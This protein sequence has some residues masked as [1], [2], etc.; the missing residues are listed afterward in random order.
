M[1]FGVAMGLALMGVLSA[2]REKARRANC[3][4]N[5]HC[6]TLSFYMYSDIFSGK[7]PLDNHMTIVGSFQL[8]S[9]VSSTAKLLFCPSDSRKG[10]R[11]EA[12][13]SNL[14]ARSI[15]YSYVPNLEL[16]NDRTNVIL[17]LDRIYTM[18]QGDKWPADGNHRS[19]GG[20]VAFTDG[21]AEFFHK[22]PVALRDKNGQ[23]S[24]LSP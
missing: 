15:S 17:W 24:L 6:C 5:L 20:N 4:G 9:N 19:A 3:L 14:T 11:A 18:E 2:A 8:L 1:V 22:L 21:H 13:Y 23:P 7:P 10:A 16:Y 12:S